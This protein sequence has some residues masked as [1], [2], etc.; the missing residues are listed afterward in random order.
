MANYPTSLA[1]D[2]TT[3]EEWFDERSI[4]RS[5]SGS[6][7]ARV[8]QS[9]KKRGWRVVHKYLSAAQKTTFQTFYD[10]NR[11]LTF[12]FALLG[13]NYT[14]IFGDEKSISWEPQKGGQWNLVVL[15]L[16]V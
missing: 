12:T 11:A 3:K 8:L 7:K 9:T 16:E 2:G 15:L 14:V 1:I 10:T 5:R 6:V 4:S 13:N